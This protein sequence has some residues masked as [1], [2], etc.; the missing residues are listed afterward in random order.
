MDEG[1]RTVG[2]TQ[3]CHSQLSKQHELSHENISPVVASSRMVN[4]G[5][6]GDNDLMSQGPMAGDPH[7]NDPQHSIYV[8]HIQGGGLLKDAVSTNYA[9]GGGSMQR[10]PLEETQGNKTRAIY[11]SHIQGGGLLPGRDWPIDT[12]STNYAQGGGS[13][14]DRPLSHMTQGNI[15]DHRIYGSHTQQGGLLKSAVS[16][17]YIQEGGSMK[18]YFLDHRSLQRTPQF[19]TTN[20]DILMQ[21][22]T[23]YQAPRGGRIY[24]NLPVDQET[25]S[26]LLQDNLVQR[27]HQG[28]GPLQMMPTPV[29]RDVGLN[30]AI[31]S[32]MDDIRTYN[33]QK[34]RIINYTQNGGLS[35]GRHIIHST[36]ARHT[37]IS[38]GTNTQMNGGSSGMME[39]HGDTRGYGP[40]ESGYIRDRNSQEFDG[41]QMPYKANHLQNLDGV[42]EPPYMTPWPQSTQMETGHGVYTHSGNYQTLQNTHEIQQNHTIFPNS[43]M[44][45]NQ[46][47][48]FNPKWSGELISSMSPQSNNTTHQNSQDFRSRVERQQGPQEARYLSKNKKIACYDGNTDWNDYLVQFEMVSQLNGWN[49]ETKAMELATSL[50]GPAL[51]VMV[52]LDPTMRNNY[53]ELVS[54]LENRFKPAASVE[55]YRMQMKNKVKKRSESLAELVEDIKRLVRQAYPMFPVTMREP[56]AMDCFID[57]LPDQDMRWSIYQSKPKGI[58]E[59]LKLAS[60][61][62][63]F[64]MA[65]DRKSQN[66]T[67]G[68]MNDN[69][70]FSMKPEPNKDG[71]M[72]NNPFAKYKCKNCGGTGHRV[73]KCP[74]DH[75]CFGC[76]EVGHYRRECP[77]SEWPGNRRSQTKTTGNMEE[78]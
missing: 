19:C 63:G 12:V 41:A 8:S 44:D 20:G 24:H 26:V 76:G 60:E 77:R 31:Y 70:V 48:T 53:T 22:G 67:T 13:L 14:S 75:K 47:S 39:K 15:P 46:A 1:Y 51:S 6:T 28:T 59:A 62:E 54:A 49:N 18:E 2:N 33:G 5:A 30:G 17:N 58:D 78:N 23:G 73:S 35:E 40:Q 16:T 21:H 38:Q 74:S 7:W 36:P 55:I 52:D 45:R 4:Q 37:F 66:K 65:V 10:I 3:N 25:H 56:L 57:A 68:R 29:N 50:K 9:Q 64:R 43:S 42:G 71:S 32:D 69:F 27:N 61:Y 72:E 34:G 11:V